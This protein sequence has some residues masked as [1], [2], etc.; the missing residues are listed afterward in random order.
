MVSLPQGVIV[1]HSG[2]DLIN[3]QPM[4]RVQTIICSAATATAP[5]TL[6]KDLGAYSS[7]LLRRTSLLD[8]HTRTNT[9]ANIRVVTPAGER[10]VAGFAMIGWSYIFTGARQDWGGWGIVH[11]FN[12]NPAA[13]RGAPVVD[14]GTRAMT[15]EARVVTA[16]C[17]PLFWHE[18]STG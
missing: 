2:F 1:R 11:R 13:D 3:Q 6:Q 5:V 18:S 8:P 10:V 12:S 14:V 15:P 16:V 7:E 9:T 17:L 4:M